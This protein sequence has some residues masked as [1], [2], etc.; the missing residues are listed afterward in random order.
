MFEDALL[1]DPAALAAADP[2]LRPLAE[3]GARVRREVATAQEVL[4]GFESDVR[5]RAVVAAGNDSRLLRAVLEPWC[6]VPFVAWPGP[7]LPGWVGALDAVVVMAQTQ[8]DVSA[9]SAASEATRRGAVLIVT[10]HPHSDVAEMAAGRYTTLLPVT[11]GDPLAAA[12]VLLQALH[13]LELGPDVDAEAVATA[14]DRVAE[15]CSPFHDIVQNPAKELALL[16]AD[17]NPLLWGG[18]VLAARAARRVAEAIRRVSGRSSLAADADHL[19]PVIA[20]ASPPDVFA[21]PYESRASSTQT[22]LV[23]LD[24]GTQDSVVR[25]QRGRLMAG[26]EQHGVR[27]TTLECD[28]GPEIARYAS[29]LSQG[30]Y[31]AAYLGVGLGSDQ[32][33]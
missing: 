20:A 19:L 26:A 4:G 2:T 1:D 27:V 16:L 15:E 29:L 7:G 28:H 25:V 13:V 30:S 6:P 10:C 17:V 31:A 32:A 18:S 5:P 33:V 14:L 23:I 8:G 9:S 24:D 11:T 12:V 3:A 21:D 22:A